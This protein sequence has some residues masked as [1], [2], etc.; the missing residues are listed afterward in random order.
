M[1]EVY[2]AL[3]LFNFLVGGVGIGLAIIIAVAYRK[4]SH[5]QQRLLSHYIY[6]VSGSW[7]ALAVAALVVSGRSLDE[8][9]RWHLPF[10]TVG[11]LLGAAAFGLLIKHLNNEVQKR[12]QLEDSTA[13]LGLRVRHIV[14]RHGG[15]QHHFNN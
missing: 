7:I 2:D 6:A 14:R 1:I 12:T 11:L 10:Y 5:V 9:F 3:R 8:G 13:L 15:H 4:V